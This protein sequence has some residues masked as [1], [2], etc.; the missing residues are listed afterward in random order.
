VGRPGLGWRKNKKNHDRTWP[1]QPGGLTQQNPVKNSFA[2]RW[3]LFFLFFVLLKR[4]RFEF[5]LKI[6]ISLADPMT[7]SKPKTQILNRASHQTGFKNYGFTNST[8]H[9]VFRWIDCDYIY[10]WPSDV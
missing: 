3:L 8:S 5:F 10:R 4:H 2:T 9:S 1:D 7:R 6:E